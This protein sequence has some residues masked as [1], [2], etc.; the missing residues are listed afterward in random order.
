MSY[1]PETLAGGA[2]STIVDFGY[3]NGGEGMSVT[4]TIA[5]TEVT[6]LSRFVYKFSDSADHNIEEAV[7]EQIRPLVLAIV[8]GVSFDLMVY[9]PTDTWG[10]YNLT[11]LVLH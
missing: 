3:P 10:T 8:P 7:L 2:I 5:D 11:I 1:R 4:Q 9:A 6:A